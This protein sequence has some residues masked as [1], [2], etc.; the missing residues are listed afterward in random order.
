MISLMVF[1]DCARRLGLDAAAVLGPTAASGP[2]WFRETFDAF[3]RR[4]DLE[5]AAFGW[6]LVETPEGTSYR[7]G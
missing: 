6:S 3:V 7:F 5:L 1:V 4:D 2:A